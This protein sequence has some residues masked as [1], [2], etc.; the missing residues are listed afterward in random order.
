[1][2]NELI[3]LSSTIVREKIRNGRPVKDDIPRPAY[4]YLEKH[5]LLEPS[6][7]P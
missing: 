4:D 2:N 5:N 7:A 6:P 3:D 1:M